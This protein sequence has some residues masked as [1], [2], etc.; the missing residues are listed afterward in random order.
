[1]V[2][3]RFTVKELLQ[4]LFFY[5][6]IIIFVSQQMTCVI[7]YISKF[8]F[9]HFRCVHMTFVYRLVQSD[10]YIYHQ[11]FVTTGALKS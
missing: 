8:T 5:M 9:K 10:T 1:M 11:Y 7:Y 2:P 3:V 4:I 6:H